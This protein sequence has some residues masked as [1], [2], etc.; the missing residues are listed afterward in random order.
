MA[1][2]L[3]PVTKN[4]KFFGYADA[5]QIA[6]TP[7]LEVFDPREAKAL[8]H[9]AAVEKQA[10][11]DEEAKARAEAAKGKQATPDAVKKGPARSE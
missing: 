1:D 7:S 3:I 4:G 9:K 10:K 5:K 8:E 2:D 6:R 11:A